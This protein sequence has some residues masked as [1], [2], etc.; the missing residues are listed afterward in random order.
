MPKGSICRY[1]EEQVVEDTFTFLKIFII[2]QF[3]SCIHLPTSCGPPTTPPNLYPLSPYLCTHP[4]ICI[5]VSISFLTHTSYC[6]L[7]VHGHGA[8]SI[9]TRHPYHRPHC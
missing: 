4:S 1:T 8:P 9:G 6:C 2:L 5:S 7:Y 3:N